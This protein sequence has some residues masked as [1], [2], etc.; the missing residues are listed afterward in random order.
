MNEMGTAAKGAAQATDPAIPAIGKNGELYPV[1]KLEAHKL[2]V[3]HLAIS[4]F[5]FCG[6]KLLIQRR[7]MGKYHSGGQWANSCCSHP[8]WGEATH[9]C[10][11]RR[12]M[13]ELGFTIPLTQMGTSEYEADV[14]AGLRENER[15]DL[16]V[17]HV[18]ED[19]ITVA[20][21]P[22][23]V[24]DTRWLSAGELRAEMAETPDIYTPW[25]RIYVERWPDLQL[26]KV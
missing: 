15:V 23:E 24:S 22:D 26:P 16:F 6:D 1:G 3:Q 8:H 2:G 5:V 9:V 13:E 21:N 25:F 20:P 10:A 7:A 4:A 12:L 11:E 18:G 14:G 17:G 19:E